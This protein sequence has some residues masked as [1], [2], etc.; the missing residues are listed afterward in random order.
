MAD[1]EIERKLKS[2]AHKSSQPHPQGSGM[3]A[4]NKWARQSGITPVTAWRFRKRGWITTLNIAGRQYLTFEE[5]ERFTR[6]AAAG[7]FAREHK[8]PTCHHEAAAA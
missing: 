1:K 4:L 3:I 6:R 7:E 8:T 5:L 2:Q